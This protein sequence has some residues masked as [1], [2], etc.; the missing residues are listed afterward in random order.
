MVRNQLLLL[1]RE[2]LIFQIGVLVAWMLMTHE[3][4]NTIKFF[5]NWVKEVSPMVWPIIF[6]TDCDQAQ[7]MAIEAVYSKTKILLC[8]WHV[9]CMIRSHFVTEKFLVL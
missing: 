7:I 2:A 8:L 3:M 6:M 9:L 4:T 1:V 5:L